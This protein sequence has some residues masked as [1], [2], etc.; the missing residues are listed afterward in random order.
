MGTSYNPKIVTDGL[1]LNLDAGN[2]KSYSG[3][4]T[5][6]TDLTKN[7]YAG[8]LTSGPVYNASNGGNISFDGVDDYVSIPNGGGLNNSTTYSIDI[9][10]KYNSTSQDAGFTGYGALCGRQKDG[11]WSSNLLYI[12]GV[13]PTTSKLVFQLDLASGPSILSVLNIGTNINHCI[14]TCTTNDIK[15]Y[16]NGIVS[17]TSVAGTTVRNDSTVPL[18]MGAWIGGGASY[19]N[20][21]IYN[22]KVYNRVLTSNEVI[23]NYHAI[24]GRFSL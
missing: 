14:I 5:T 7:K 8:T 4:G 6:W 12:N 9:W 13:N 20:S 18:T 15:M 17:S 2:R 19:S 24:K 10:F 1:V 3:A 11:S 22:F 16:I 23:Q 21:Y